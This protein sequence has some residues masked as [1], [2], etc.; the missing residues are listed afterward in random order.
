[1]D[2]ETMKQKLEPLI[3][4]M[5]AAWESLGEF[6]PEMLDLEEIRDFIKADRRARKASMKMRKFVISLVS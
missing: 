1:M 5:E 3:E 2:R 6:E 4:E